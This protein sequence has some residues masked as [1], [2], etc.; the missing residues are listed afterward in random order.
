VCPR[1]ISDLREA[2][3]KIREQNWFNN[4]VAGGFFY[5]E[6]NFNLEEM[7]ANPHI[8]ALLHTTLPGSKKPLNMTKGNISWKRL[9]K[10]GNLQTPQSLRTY[11]DAVNI[12]AYILKQEHRGEPMINHLCE[13]I[14]TLKTEFNTAYDTINSEHETD[15]LVSEVL[16]CLKEEI[17]MTEEL[18][19]E[20]T[21]IYNTVF[22]D[23]RR[24]G[25]FG[26]W[27]G[28]NKTT[29]SNTGWSCRTCG[30]TQSEIIYT[31]K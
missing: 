17:Q 9:T 31:E 2:F 23:Q 22:A 8:H 3:A 21:R 10:G 26:S 16:R 30:S 18:R 19:F 12:C 13:R 11:D 20:L 6:M 15:D 28:K 14:H 24:Y 7:T 29:M 25:F 5:I 1:D 27:Y 4:I